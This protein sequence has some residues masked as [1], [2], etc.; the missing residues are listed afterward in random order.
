MSYRELSGSPDHD[1]DSLIVI[2]E[3]FSS[4]YGDFDA[5]P[6]VDE[7]AEVTS[8]TQCLFY[9]GTLLE[10]EYGEDRTKKMFRAAWREV[11]A[12]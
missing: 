11:R 3:H 2:L 8:W 6:T 7:V 4:A 10:E 1:L 9:F 12:G 5:G